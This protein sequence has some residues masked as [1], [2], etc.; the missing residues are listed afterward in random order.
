M[1]ECN[2]LVGQIGGYVESGADIVVLLCGETKP[3]L[4]QCLYKRLAT[5][6]G[7]KVF[8]KGHVLTM[9]LTIRGPDCRFLPGEATAAP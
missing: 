7:E 2:R 4:A 5:F 8:R 1:N 9:P 3:E 6:R